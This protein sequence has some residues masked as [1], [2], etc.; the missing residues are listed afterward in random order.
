MALYTTD[1]DSPWGP[2]R[3]VTTH[4]MIKTFRGCPREAYYKYALRLQPKH[5]SKPLTRGK[6]IHDLLDVHYKGGD[7]RAQHKRWTLKFSKLFDEEKEALGDLPR[8]IQQLM[9]SYF[10]H[11]KKDEWEV[12]DTELLVEAELPNGHIFRGKVDILIRNQYGEVW[13]GDHKSHRRLPDWDFRLLDEQSTLYGWALGEMGRP[14]KG[15]FW[16][17]MVTEAISSPK[18]VKDGSRFYAK[19]GNTDY[20]TLVKAIRRARETVDPDWPSGDEERSRLRALLASLKGQQFDPM[21]PLQSSPFFRRDYLVKT[22]DLV[23]RVL[24]GVVRTS[25]RMHSY[26]FSDPDSVERSIGTCKSFM[27]HYKALNLADLMSGD[28][29]M[30]ARRD[31]QKGDPLAYYEEEGA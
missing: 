19:L 8:E 5:L 14:V 2:N 28:S 23:E 16:N 15:F 4:S 12:L 29:S 31:F 7:W 25:D 13:A 21:N 26:D 9:E 20:P 24:A 11:Y 17:Y 3:P 30:V 10:W 27:C 18:L 1:A 22:P 6:W